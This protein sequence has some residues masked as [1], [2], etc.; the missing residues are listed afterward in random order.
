MY[1]HQF[2]IIKIDEPMVELAVKTGRKI[3][4]V[5]TLETTLKLTIRLIENKAT[6]INKQVL[7]KVKFARMLSMSLLMGIETGMMKLFPK[8]L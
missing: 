5:A 7:L 6:E 8:Q 1:A 3:G 2:N 4:V